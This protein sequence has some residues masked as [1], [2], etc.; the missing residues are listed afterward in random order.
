MTRRWPVMR[1]PLARQARSMALADPAGGSLCVLCRHQR[2]G[3]ALLS[4]R[5]TERRGRP[6]TEALRS[7]RLIVMAAAR[8]PSGRA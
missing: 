6:S 7:V 8:V 4:A 1:R 2:P 5:Y 3:V